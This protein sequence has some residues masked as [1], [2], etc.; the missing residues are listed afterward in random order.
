MQAL[1]VR[2]VLN[3]EDIRGDDPMV[4]AIIDAHRTAK[5]RDRRRAFPEDT[6]LKDRALFEA[7]LLKHLTGQAEAVAQSEDFTQGAGSLTYDIAEIGSTAA[8]LR[9]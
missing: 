1:R 8:S 2:D 4:L 5:T 7:L 6:R 3:A 9:K